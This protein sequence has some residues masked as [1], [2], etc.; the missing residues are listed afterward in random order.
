MFYSRRCTRLIVDVPTRKTMLRYL[1][2]FIYRFVSYK[3]LILCLS[4]LILHVFHYFR[5]LCTRLVGALKVEDYRFG[6]TMHAVGWSYKM[7]GLVG[8]VQSNRIRSV[9]VQLAHLTSF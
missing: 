1:N 2:I 6:W 9:L 4:L 5:S 3:L 7:A 8:P